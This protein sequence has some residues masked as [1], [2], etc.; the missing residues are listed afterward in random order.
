MNKL[1][2]ISNSILATSLA[3]VVAFSACGK[4]D[5]SATEMGQKKAQEL[6]NCFKKTSGEE[7]QSC[8]QNLNAKSEYLKYEE[9]ADFVNAFQ[10]E[11][12]KC[13]ANTPCWWSGD[14]ED[15]PAEAGVKKAQE[16]CEC[17]KKSSEADAKSCV[18]ILNAKPEYLK[19]EENADFEN[20]FH[21]E[22]K[23]C[24]TETPDW[25]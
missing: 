12:E 21:Q 14:C 24:N 8:V 6:C 19:Y 9:N 23:N 2:F 17:F 1:K 22:R 18:Q 5:N 7:G 15:T 13:D 20:A 16:L 3:G 25:W 10:K 11:L 4:K